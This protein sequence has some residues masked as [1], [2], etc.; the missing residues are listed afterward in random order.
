MFITHARGYTDCR[1]VLLYGYGG[2]NVSVVPVY[3]PAFVSFLQGFSGAVAC[4][5]LRGGG[6]YGEDWHRAG[7]LE[8]KQNVLDGFHHAA[9]H[10][11]QRDL[12]THNWIIAM[13]GSN[14]GLVVAAYLNQRPGL[15]GCVL[16]KVAELDCL[17]Y[18]MSAAGSQGISEIGDPKDPQAFDYLRAYSPLHNIHFSAKSRGSEEHE[19][20]LLCPPVLLLTADRDNRVPP[21]HPLKHVAE[22]Q[23]FQSSIVSPI[24]LLGIELGRGKS[25]W[26]G[27]KYEIYFRDFSAIRSCADVCILGCSFLLLVLFGLRWVTAVGFIVETL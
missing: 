5:N 2:F 20:G 4:V 9:M 16:I 6:E 12:A 17:R 26:R 14:G 3:N 22:L 15:Y 27:K 8:R 10:L 1:P 11:V 19:D 13:G 18:T 23:H 24:M 25:N 21:M 7:M